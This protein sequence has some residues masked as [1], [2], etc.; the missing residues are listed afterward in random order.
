MASNRVSNL[1]IGSGVG[2]MGVSAVMYFQDQREQ[3]LR[4]ATFV[5]VTSASRTA[6]IAS[7]VSTDPA[8]FQARVKTVHAT[9]DGPVALQG[10]SV[11]DTVSIVEKNVGPKGGYHR[12][13][14]E[15]GK[16][17]GWYP[18]QFIDQSTEKS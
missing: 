3:Q 10:V 15:D 4:E 6:N 7:K 8:L 14:S 12:C 1:L 9:F 5:D 17:E 2:L 18:V 16:R 13:R 11:G